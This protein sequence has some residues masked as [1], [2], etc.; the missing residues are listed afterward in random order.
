MSQAGRGQREKD[1]ESAHPG[2]LRR[3]TPVKIVGGNVL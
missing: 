3:E 2:T 1:D